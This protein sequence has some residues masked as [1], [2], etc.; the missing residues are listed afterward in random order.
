MTPEPQQDAQQAGQD[1]VEDLMAQIQRGAH[2]RAMLTAT[3][4]RLER[5]LASAQQLVATL[6][7]QIK[8]AP[9]TADERR[10]AAEATIDQA[11]N[12]QTLRAAG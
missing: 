4:K 11:G 1:M 6:Q 7:G 12:V 2:E 8:A 5:Q 3:V 10:A 9:A